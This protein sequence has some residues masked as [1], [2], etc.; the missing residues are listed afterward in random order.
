MVCAGSPLHRDCGKIPHSDNYVGG[1]SLAKQNYTAVGNYGHVKNNENKVLYSV[2]APP[3]EN[4]AYPQ[5][6][7]HPPVTEQPPPPNYPPPQAEPGYPPPQQPGYAPPEQMAGYPPQQPGYPPQQ[8]G[9]PQPQGYPPPTGYPQALSQQVSALY[10]QLNLQKGTLL[11]IFP[12][13]R[14]H[15]I[16]E[17]K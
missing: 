3:L 13:K 2:Q 16:F 12:L 1:H 4:P 6:D 8:P 7:A 10:I 15:P 17:V 9:Y 5:I 14:G 11:E